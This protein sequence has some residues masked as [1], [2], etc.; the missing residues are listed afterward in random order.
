MA[1]AYDV[2]IHGWVK[3]MMAEGDTVEEAREKLSDLV[4]GAC[5]EIAYGDDQ[6]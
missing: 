1:T 3:E 5:D 6:E 4:D 2:M